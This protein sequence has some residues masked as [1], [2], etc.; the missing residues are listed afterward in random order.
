MGLGTGAIIG[1]SIGSVITAILVF[2]LLFHFFRLWIRGPTRGSDNR[3]RLDGRVVA[4][5]GKISL[6]TGGLK[7]QFKRF[8]LFM[9]II[10]SIHIHISISQ[11]N[12]ILKEF[13][14]L[15]KAKIGVIID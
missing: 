7:Q 4:I 8:F 2:A 10:N 3:K 5:T 15:S 1:I 9:Y 13:F 12:Y 11:I 14:E 6:T